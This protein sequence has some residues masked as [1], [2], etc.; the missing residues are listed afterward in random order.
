MGAACKKFGTPVTGGNVSFYNQS[1]YEGP[2]FPTPTIGMLGLLEKKN[3]MTLDFK[4]EGDL[5]YVIGEM[6]D[7]M[8]CSEY[9]YSY[10]KVKLSPAPFFDL[11]E[12]FKVQQ[13]VNAIIKKGF[14]RSA[15]DCSDGGLFVAL[16]E[17]AIH[18]GKGF[19]ISTDEFIRTDAFLF[20]EGQSRVVVTIRPGDED[21]FLHEMMERDVEFSLLGTVMGDEMTVDEEVFLKVDAAKQVYESSLENLLK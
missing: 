12:E 6:R 7:D 3:R 15:H 5:I 16:A 8:A 21:S 20:G 9:L 11:D 17:S 4:S 19:D 14:V 2:V 18:S 13:A 1:S 10:H